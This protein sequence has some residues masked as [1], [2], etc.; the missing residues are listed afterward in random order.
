MS[1]S[2]QVPLNECRAGE[3]IYK[4]GASTYYRIRETAISRE[5]YRGAVVGRGRAGVY[6]GVFKKSQGTIY[7]TSTVWQDIAFHAGGLKVYTGQ[8]I[9]R[10]DSSRANGGN[11]MT[12][13][14]R[15]LEA[16]EVLTASEAVLKY[17]LNWDVEKRPVI[18]DGKEAEDYRAIVRSDNGRIFQIAGS[19]YEPIQNRDA[20]RF[21]DAI[22]GT[23]QAKYV[24][25]GAYKG[26]AVTWLRARIPY[27]F[28]VLPGDKVATYLKIV[29]SHDGSHKLTIYPESFRLI[30][31]NG[32]GVWQREY[33]YTVA[34]KHTE[35]AEARFVFNSKN[36]LEKYIS[37]FEK[38]SAGCRAL[39]EKQF[40]GLQIDSFLE[41]LF[42]VKA[43]EE[44]GTKQKN[45]IE[46][47]RGLV[48]A[49][50]GNDLP[51]V[52]GTAWAVFNAVTEYID[53]YRPTKGE[54]ENR[55]YSAEFG[56]G[57]DLRESA[58]ELLLKA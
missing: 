20:F 34:V 41:S 18:V 13:Q 19:R 45:Q 17:G 53:N 28:E 37:Y 25:A 39:A 43:G 21:F 6:R 7:K 48:G 50:T 1:L 40:T 55:E 27:D 2:V 11:K 36:V 42:E 5:R 44:V 15:Q 30:C 46:A 54:A 8:R 10:V 56:S 58:F 29:N 51:G 57:R 49:G 47:I 32:A 35:N 12:R 31:T 52:K 14:L 24:N 23:G 3:V 16:G 9:I 33:A 22:V 4:P 26:G 38:F